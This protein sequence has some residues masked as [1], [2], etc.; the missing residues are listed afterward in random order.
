M[1]V[2]NTRMQSTPPALR[3]WHA[4]SPEELGEDYIDFTRRPAE[5]TW[6]TVPGRDTTRSRAI[7]TLLHG[8]EP[9]GVKAVFD[10]LKSDRPPA[11]NLGIVVASVNAALMDPVFSHRYLPDERDLNRCFTKP[12]D[13]NQRRLAASIL[14]QLGEFAPEA[15]ID[16]HNTSGHSEP[17]AVATR[18]DPATVQLAQRFTNRLVVLD[19]RL[20]TLIEHARPAMPIATIEFGGFTDPRADALARESLNGFV[21]SRDLFDADTRP[22]MVL[23]HP[24]RLE[25]DETTELH[26]SSMV[27]DRA[28]VTIFNT[29]DQLN[30]SRIEAG[31]PLGWIDKG[32]S[33]ICG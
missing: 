5:P 31:Q 23:R 25:V 20:G 27:A 17:F 8:N 4:P 15:V 33:A 7:V 3:H 14:T 19:L 29:I 2:Y 12:A 1:L 18:D 30:F 21:Y 9:S 16:T 22:M 32:R 28:D 10:L 6:I 26:Y 13:T 11:T 24:H